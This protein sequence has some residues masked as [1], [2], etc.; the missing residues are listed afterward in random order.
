[1]LRGSREVSLSQTTVTCC[2][3]IKKGDTPSMQGLTGG[4]WIRGTLGRRCRQPREIHETLLARRS[5]PELAL[6]PPMDPFKF[7]NHQT[8][9]AMAVEWPL[10]QLRNSSQSHL[11][12]I[13]HTWFFLSSYSFSGL[14]WEHN[15]PVVNYTKASTNSK[16]AIQ[17][18]F[19]VGV[20]DSS[21]DLGL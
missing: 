2:L 1:M 12:P 10:G 19:R 9:E 4:I 18:L 16:K 20:V 7:C 14:K 17:T 8:S 11:R 6:K 15:T 21:W 13:C 3:S 5:S